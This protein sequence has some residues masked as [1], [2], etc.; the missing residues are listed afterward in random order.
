[1]RTATLLFVSARDYCRR[2]DKAMA[3]I[4]DHN[5]EFFD[6]STLSSASV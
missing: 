1:M 2:G 3:D 6:C 4:V 5:A